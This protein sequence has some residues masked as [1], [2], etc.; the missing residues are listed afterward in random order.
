MKAQR[1]FLYSLLFIVSIGACDDSYESNAGEPG[2]TLSV[3]GE[4]IK[5]P[6]YGQY[7]MNALTGAEVS[8]KASAPSALTSLTITKTVNLEVD[9]DYGTNGVLTATPSGSEYEFAYTPHESDLDQLIGFTFRAQTADGESLTSDLTLVVTLSPRDNLPKRKWLFVS[10]IWVD[11]DNT[12]DIK[13]CEKDDYWYFN[14]DGSVTIDYGTDTGSGDCAYD[15]FNV[16][17]SWELSEDETIF[18]L[19]YHSLFNPSSI[20]TEVFKVKTLTVDK[21]ELEI[22]YDLSWLGYG[23][24]ETFIYEYKAEAK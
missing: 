7:R 6:G 17:D 8:L 10:K 22:D 21:L 5:A 13:S 18:T 24:E 16:Y 12:Q 4:S 20:T 14:S 11:L 1:I 19:V 2:L 23:T 3:Y 15:G 9:P